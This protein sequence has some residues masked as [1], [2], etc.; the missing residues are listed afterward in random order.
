MVR[1]D[2]F[3]RL[4][5]GMAIIATAVAASFFGASVPVASAATDHFATSDWL[6]N[7]YGPWR[8][9]TR[10]YVNDLNNGNGSCENALNTNSTWAQSVHWC[11]WGGSVYHD[12][13][14]C[15]NRAGNARNYSWP[16]GTALMNA[17]QNY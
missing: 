4:R 7:A 5:V 17:H 2:S 12:F 10:V 13:C 14:G 8:H 3:A 16:S 6:G 15:H 9:L 1:R 11:A